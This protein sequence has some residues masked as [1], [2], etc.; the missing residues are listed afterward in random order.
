MLDN[1]NL[2]IMENDYHDIEHKNYVNRVLEAKG[3][4][5]DYVEGNENV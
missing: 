5:R 1:I 3:F 2:V 4:V